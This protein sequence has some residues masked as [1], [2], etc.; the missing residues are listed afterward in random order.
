MHFVYIK[1]VGWM[2][3]KQLFCTCLSKSEKSDLRMMGFCFSTIKFSQENKNLKISSEAKK[4][5]NRKKMQD[6]LQESTFNLTMVW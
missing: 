6:I 3:S 1:A 2:L 5:L 4:K